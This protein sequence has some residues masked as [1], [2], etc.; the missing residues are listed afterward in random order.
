M[1]IVIIGAGVVGAFIA[2]NLSKYRLSVLL[3]DKEN[4]VGN[5]VSNANSAII[6]SGYDPVPGTLKA[7]FN[8]LANPMWDEI[9]SDLD[10]H[11]YREGSLTVALYDEQIPMLESLALRS[12]EN[13]V[14]VKLLNKEEVLKME[15]N[16]NP[17]VKA[18]LFAPTCGIIDPFNAVVH[19]MENAVDNGVELFL[20]NRVENIQKDGEIYKNIKSYEKIEKRCCVMK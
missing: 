10:I 16:I 14:E 12:K 8:V 13:G 17:N 1:K 11:F 9:A 3:I 15:P 6:H 19:C 7:K 4:D 2:R 20:N 18:A 5:V